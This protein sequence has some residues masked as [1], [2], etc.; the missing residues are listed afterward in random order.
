MNIC[1]HKIFNAKFIIN[2]T[3]QEKSLFQLIKDTYKASPT[4]ILVAYND[5][6]SVIT[7]L[8]QQS[9]YADF[10][11][12]EY[13]S[14]PMSSH[15]LM[16]VETHNH[17]T[18]IEPF[19]GAATGSGGE[20]RDE[21][22]TGIGAQPK[23]GLCGFSVSNLNLTGYDISYGKPAHIQSALNI[24]LAGPIGAASFNNE[25]GRPNLCGYF[26]SFEQVVDNIHYGYHKPIMLAGGYGQINHEHVYKATNIQHD[27]VIVQI[28]GPGFLI[29][30]GGGSASSITGGTN[31]LELDFNSVQRSN[32]EMREKM[33][34]SH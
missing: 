10:N 15:I 28:G 16:K 8:S 11:T 9:F 17:P 25:F 23:A 26:R 3:V 34:R 13:Q 22:A 31:N 5:N 24:M 30:L 7:G 4:N 20:I 21:G 33:S 32:P 12:H 14:H 19:S 18:A 29:G 1:R 6:S 2:G 27:A